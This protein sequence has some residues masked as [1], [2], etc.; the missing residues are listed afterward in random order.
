MKSPL[1]CA[2][3]LWWQCTCFHPFG[4][5]CQIL[6][7]SIFI[8]SNPLEIIRSHVQI[9]ELLLKT[10]TSI[11][12]AF[13]HEISLL[14]TS[15][16]CMSRPWSK[17]PFDS[18]LKEVT[19][20]SVRETKVDQSP[21]CI[22]HKSVS[23]NS[24]IWFSNPNVFRGLRGLEGPSKTP[25]IA[26]GTEVWLKFDVRD[27]I[28]GWDRCLDGGGEGSGSVN[29][30][31]AFFARGYTSSLGSVNFRNALFVW[32]KLPRFGL[33]MPKM[34]DPS[35]SLPSSLSWSLFSSG[36]SETIDSTSSK[37][38]GFSFN[39]LFA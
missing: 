29:F 30:R 19:F 26:E 21:F 7:S 6:V 22:A 25:D 14:V 31:R 9:A 12:T 16:L 4:V 27:C 15:S 10:R 38:G 35:S 39:L 33:P 11:F 18:G 28:F 13:S 34:S 5:S 37:S 1:L 2:C 23:F 32:A 24:F 17:A 36:S 3:W 8:V 20:G